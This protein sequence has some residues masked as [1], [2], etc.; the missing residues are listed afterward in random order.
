MISSAH[1]FRDIFTSTEADNAV[2][3]IVIPIVQR[4]YAQ[5]RKAPEVKRIRDRFLTVLYDAV[6]NV[7]IECDNTEQKLKRWK[8]AYAECIETLKTEDEIVRITKAQDDIARAEKMI[9][10]HSNALKK[11]TEKLNTGKAELESYVTKELHNAYKVYV[12]SQDDALL[13]VYTLKLANT[14]DTMGIPVGIKGV[15]YVMRQFGVVCASNKDIMKNNGT[16]LIKG[17]SFKAYRETMCRV[18][19][20]LV[21]EKCPVAKNKFDAY[22]KR[23]EKEEKANK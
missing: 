6:V 7:A 3:G 8:N 19:A 11:A 14:L 16:V 5:G 15:N 13:K 12:Q 1:N 17:M 20:Q 9:E 2:K 21:C 18:L 22:N 4:D 23:V 10:K